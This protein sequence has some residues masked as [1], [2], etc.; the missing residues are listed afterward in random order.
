MLFLT[1]NQECQSTEGK[2]TP[3][4]CHI[5]WRPG[6]SFQHWCLCCF[7]SLL[8]PPCIADADVIFLPCGFFFFSLAQSQQLQ[9]GCLPYFHTW[10]GLSANFRCRSEMCCKRLHGNAG[11]KK[12][13]KNRHLGTIAQLC[14]AISL[15]LRHV[16][17]VGEKNLLSSNVSSRSPHNMVNFGPLAAQIGPVVFGHPS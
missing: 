16:L 10:C 3:E 6:N 12:V 8:W 14:W 5:L 1:P 13:A 17:T 9:T 11:R 15:Q 4:R 2:K 7:I